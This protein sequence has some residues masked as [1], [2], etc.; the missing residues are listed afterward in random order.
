MIRVVF[1]LCMLVAV[2]LAGAGIAAGDTP[3]RPGHLRAQVEVPNDIRTFTQAAEQEFAPP[4]SNYVDLPPLV[5]PVTQSDRLVAYAFVTIRLHLAANADEWRVREQA[6]F[7]M[8]ELVGVAHQM[9][10]VRTSATQFV[11]EPTR[12]LWEEGV[13]TR[14]TRDR[15]ERLEI[16][17]GDMRPLRG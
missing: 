11:S 2:S 10:F 3:A 1:A 8:H 15:L 14:L 12:E 13:R 7:L 5:V 6:H 17:G 4:G 9:P 16:L